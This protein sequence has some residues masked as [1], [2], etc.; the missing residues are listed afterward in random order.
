[1]QIS[2]KMKKKMKMMKMLKNLINFIEIISNYMI[3]KL[4]QVLWK[5]IKEEETEKIWKQ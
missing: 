1:M 5:E 2:I 3:M 4:K